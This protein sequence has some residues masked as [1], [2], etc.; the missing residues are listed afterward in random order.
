MATT[1]VREK[2]T[3]KD[4]LDLLEQLNAAIEDHI[5]EI[6]LND[7]ALPDWMAAMLDEIE[8]ATADRV[9]AI[10][11]KIDEF[12]GYATTAKA[13]KDRSA[14]R[15]RVWNN[16]IASMKNY[17]LHQVQRSGGDRL[18]G[19]SATLR[20]QNNS[21]PST[22]VNVTDQQLLDYWDID[23]RN[24]AVE[25]YQ[26]FPLT[27]YVSVARVVS[28]DKK[29]LAAAYEARHADLVAESEVI[30]DTDIPDVIIERFGDRDEPPTQEEV[31]AVL[32]DVRSKYVADNLA[33]EFPGVQ[34][35]RGVHL[36]ID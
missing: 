25:G 31:A 20:I 13:T 7:G 16:V 35:V 10:A 24:A 1:K 27:K 23:T 11:A 26:P 30:C 17:G 34:C 2:L 21:A 22:S 4:A 36:R 18:R 28:I 29:A 3:L 12:A 33:L 15:E 9:D 8:A 6:E 32:G 5:D 19:V 14:R